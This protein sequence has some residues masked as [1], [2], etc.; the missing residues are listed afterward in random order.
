M[1]DT[2]FGGAVSYRMGGGSDGETGGDDIIFGDILGPGET[3][4]G[5]PISRGFD[6]GRPGSKVRQRKRT[7]G[8][9]INNGRFSIGSPES[10]KTKNEA[11]EM[12][13]MNSKHRNSDMKSSG[14]D[15]KPVRE[16]VFDDI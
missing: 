13:N 7:G 1:V 14:S 10:A 11:I 12:H 6:A 16:M 3:S 5:D 9:S 8:A 4:N 2:D 15:S